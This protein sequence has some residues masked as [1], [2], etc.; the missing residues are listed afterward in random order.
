MALA[1]LKVLKSKPLLNISTET[2]DSELKLLLAATSSY[3]HSFCA[4]VLESASYSDEYYSGDGSHTLYL[5]Q[6]P[7]TAVTTVKIWDGT[8]SYDTETA[9]YYTLVD[10]RYLYY[11]AIGQESNST[12]SKWPD[13]RNNIK[14]TYTAGYATTSWATAAITDAFGVPADLEMAVARL[15]MLRWMDGLGNEGRIGLQSLNPSGERETAQKFLT[16]MPYDIKMVLNSY[17]RKL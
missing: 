12:Y 7:V 3:V 14:I 11:P 1:R 17:R 15:T 5:T 8:D 4:R 10:S 2:V 16:E 13:K 9:T 6:W